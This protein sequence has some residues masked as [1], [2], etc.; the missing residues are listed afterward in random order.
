MSLLLQAL[1]KAA[2][3]REGA[4]PTPEPVEIEP[5]RPEPVEQAPVE[6]IEPTPSQVEKLKEPELTLEEEE[7][8]EPEEIAPTPAAEQFEPFAAPAPSAAQAATILRANE[9]QTAGW[10]DWVRDRPVHTFAVLA[11]VFLVFYGVYVYLQLNHPALLRGDFLSSPLTAKAPAPQAQPVNQPV[12]APAPPPAPALA[13]PAQPAPAPAA[14]ATPSPATTTA[15]PPTTIAGIPQPAQSRP[16]KA[17]QPDRTM[18]APAATPRR[19]PVSANE[20]LPAASLPEDQVS[21]APVELAPASVAPGIAEA[22]QAIERG[23]LNRAES[24]YR[25]VLQADA[26][27]VDAVLG[28]ATIAARRGNAQQAIGFYEQALRL[29]PRNSAA[30]AGLID[31]IGQADPQLSESR[32]KQLIA[33]EPSGFLY[34]SLGNLYARE[35]AWPA[36]Q[37]AYFQA[38]NLQPDNPDYAYN[39]AIGLEHLEQPKLALT[40]YRKALDLSFKKGHANF[41][42]NRVIERVGQLAARVN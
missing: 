33:R 31:I 18:R 41:D 25:G 14:T 17:A 2:K 40:Y 5:A 16:A 23:D 20:S 42:Q 15:A 22:Y 8:F 12:P 32:L 37:A 38:Y 1:Q 24:L 30:Q 29:E 11:G 10:I 26:Q 9:A 35:S 6:P 3:N 4:A 21:K 39:L 27:N 34:F 19:A 28:L 36:A 13:T 7:L